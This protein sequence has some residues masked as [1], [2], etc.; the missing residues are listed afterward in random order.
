[1]SIGAELEQY[2]CANRHKN[3]DSIGGWM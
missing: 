2:F 1:M 3:Q